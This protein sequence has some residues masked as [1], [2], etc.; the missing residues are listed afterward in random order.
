MHCYARERESESESE[1]EILFDRPQA[2]TNGEQYEHE[3]LIHELYTYILL[4]LQSHGENG[5]KRLDS[6]AT[7]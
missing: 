6:L 7:I 2:L 1:S 5:D 4:F 3:S